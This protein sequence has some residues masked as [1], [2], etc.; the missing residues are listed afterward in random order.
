MSTNCIKCVRNPRTGTDLLCDACRKEN[1][2]TGPD[3]PDSL[4]SFNVERFLA[5]HQNST[6]RQIAVG[7]F[8]AGW[9]QRFADDGKPVRPPCPEITAQVFRPDRVPGPPPV[10][11][12]PD[13]PEQFA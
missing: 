13:H 10:P 9:S 11:R 6:L 7:A 4:P 1:V 12:N 5:Y 8:R 2:A 3:K